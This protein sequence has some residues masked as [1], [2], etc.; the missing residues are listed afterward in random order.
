VQDHTKKENA[1]FFTILTVALHCVKV[2][3]VALV[4]ICLNAK[5][6]RREIVIKTV[7]LSSFLVFFPAGRA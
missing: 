3:P 4:A 5:K 1:Y 2:L 7:C 6:K